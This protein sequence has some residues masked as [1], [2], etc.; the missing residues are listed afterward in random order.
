MRL[1]D[2]QCRE[3]VHALEA[4]DWRGITLNDVR[5]FDQLIED[6]RS[7]EE[8]SAD[9]CRDGKFFDGRLIQC[10]Q[11]EG[12]GGTHAASINGVTEQ[13]TSENG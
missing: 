7:A 1:T 11:I 9:R 5:M 6:A 4:R 13:W 8:T 2:L 10:C 3:V 12:H